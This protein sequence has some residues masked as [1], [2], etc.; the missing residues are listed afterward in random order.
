MLQRFQLMLNRWNRC[1]YL[2]YAFPNA[3]PVPTFAGNALKRAVSGEA[4]AALSISLI[5]L[6]HLRHLKPLSRR[7]L[8]CVQ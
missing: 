5:I 8:Y 2:F 6:A 1:N 3:K 7:N 4:E